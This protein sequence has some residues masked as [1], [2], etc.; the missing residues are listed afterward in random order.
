MTNTDAT[1]TDREVG[2]R[3]APKV[4]ISYR[5][6]DTA[7]DVA[8]LAG[9][10]REDLGSRNVFR[11]RDSLIGGHRWQD[12]IDSSIAD[13]DA[14]LFV[15]GPSWLGENDTGRRI[16][17]A[18]DPVRREIVLALDA[19]ASPIPV[20]VDL[21]A[22]PTDLD[23]EVQALFELHAVR[24]TRADI[25]DPASKAYQ[26]IL[27][28]IW[29]ALRRKLPGGVLVLTDVD[30]NVDVSAL[31]DQLH[32]TKA[33]D[34]RK[35]SR[36]AAGV[37]LARSRRFR[38]WARRVPDV[39]VVADG[40]PSETL[41]ARLAAVAKHPR[42][43]DVALVGT[44]VA[45][46]LAA[47]ASTGGEA[48]ALSL[49]AHTQAGG[50]ADL[51]ATTTRK[52]VEHGTAGW[53]AAGIGTKVAAFVVGA[54]AVGTGVAVSWPSAVT[55]PTAVTFADIEWNVLDA[56]LTE[57]MD[58]SSTEPDTDETT[59]YVHVDIELT[60]PTTDLDWQFPIADWV[61]LELPGREFPIAAERV[62][63][64]DGQTS[65]G[66]SLPPQSQLLGTWSF[67]VPAGIDV[68]AA[69][70][71][72]GVPP[73]RTETVPIS[74]DV[75]PD[76]TAPVSLSPTQFGGKYS[77][78]EVDFEVLA[79]DA[80]YEAGVN[81]D[82]SARAGNDSDRRA[83]EGTVFVTVKLRARYTEISSMR[84]G[85]N[86]GSFTIVDD[87]NFAHPCVFPRGFG[88]NKNRP[89]AEFSVRCQVPTGVTALTFVADGTTSCGPDCRPYEVTIDPSFLDAFANTG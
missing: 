40:P 82:G 38:R 62:S 81:D 44:G 52:I 89:T 28:S 18:D 86:F 87:T 30:H 69:S 60:N 33:V 47:L 43:R 21:S 13:A 5:V 58:P 73:D 6:A 53:R 15:V 57:T 32:E 71:V 66:E 84:P 45:A 4:F 72:I 50:L 1:D 80:G 48:G 56:S 10:L 42:L 59:D 51:G 63:G 24:A 65:L 49:T 3:V 11:D 26:A 74:G 9:R 79:A 55:L 41:S 2:S 67:A 68:S 7:D 27:V 31:V 77:L 17:Q 70:V 83:D 34:A 46:S 20:L 61:K 29:D 25:A 8:T 85:A 64:E 23:D 78:N 36:V 76:A 35:L 37:Y 88:M 39:I 75:T 12:S 54:A 22:P 19:D 14:T 16:D